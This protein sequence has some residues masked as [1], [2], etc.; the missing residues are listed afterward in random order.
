MVY[1]RSVD[2]DDIQKAMWGADT[3]TEDSGG[4]IR[5]FKSKKARM[6]LI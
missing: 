4:D 1:R 6:D 2:S 5:S 3:H